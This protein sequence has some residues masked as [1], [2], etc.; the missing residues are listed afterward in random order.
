MTRG[1]KVGDGRAVVVDPSTPRGDGRAEGHPTGLKGGRTVEKEKERGGGY[2]EGPS[3]RNLRSRPGIA[4][5]PHTA[6]VVCVAHSSMLI[7]LPEDRSSPGLYNVLA[8]SV[9]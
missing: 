3:A 9:P 6:I 1:L 2:G 8:P 5:W 7:S 4:V